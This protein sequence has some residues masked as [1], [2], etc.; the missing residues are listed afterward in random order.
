[1]PRDQ[2]STCNTEPITVQISCINH[3]L[4]QMFN[5]RYFTLLLLFFLKKRSSVVGIAGLCLKMLV[6]HTSDFR[7]AIHLTSVANIALFSPESIFYQNVTQKCSTERDGKRL[8][9]TLLIMFSTRSCTSSTITWKQ[10]ITSG[11]NRQVLPILA[12]QDIQLFFL[13]RVIIVAVHFKNYYAILRAVCLIHC[14]SRAALFFFCVML[15]RQW[16]C[17]CNMQTL[18]T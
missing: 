12:N 16:L 17:L 18:V 6:T 3:N 11:C 7:L 15:F 1:M 9:T 8:T 13:P 4:I 14:F 10:P 5:P 2:M